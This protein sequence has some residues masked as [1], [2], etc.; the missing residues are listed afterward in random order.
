MQTANQLHVESIRGSWMM[1]SFVRLPRIY[2]EK[3]L[4]QYLQDG[5]LCYADNISFLFDIAC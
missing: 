3:I 1:V 4:F 2:F 5:F